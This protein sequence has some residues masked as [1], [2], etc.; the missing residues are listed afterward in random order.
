MHLRENLSE[1]IKSIRANLLRSILTAC[2]IALGIMA[3]VGILTAIES[4]QT[5]INADLAGFGAKSFNISDIS[6]RGQSQ[7]KDQKTYP[8]LKYK[9]LKRFKNLYGYSSTVGI[10]STVSQSAEIKHLFEKTDPNAWVYG[11]D[12]NYLLLMDYDLESGRNFSE[13]EIENGSMVA[14]VGKGISKKLFD[15]NDAV[16]GDISFGGRKFR[17]IGQLAEKGGIGSNSGGG[18]KQVII[19]L[20]VAN[21]MSSQRRLYY[22]LNVSV[23]SQEELDFAMGEATGL[24]RSIR[25]DDLGKENSFEIAKNDSLTKALN[26]ITGY[27]R[28]GAYVI[29]IITLLGASI[30]LMNIMMVSVTER[31]REIG[32]RKALGATPLKIREQFLIEAILICIMGGISGIILGVVVGNLVSTLIGIGS[33]VTP[34]LW[35]IVGVLVCISV[36]LISG[37]L[38]AHKASKLDPIESLRFE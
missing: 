36:G 33:F 32:V 18:D 22:S 24:M 7:G 2:I 28:I 31:T 8:P 9:D 23:N 20:E 35:M 25:Q 5:K 6:R 30:G 26:D 29:G 38:P 37:Y 4:I 1:G 16:G 21:A 17:V 11:A 14:I 19:P 12:N 10:S 27:L 34:W 3:L 15:G 13:L